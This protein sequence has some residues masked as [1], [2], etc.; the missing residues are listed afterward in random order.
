MIRLQRRE[1]GP[2][3]TAFSLRILDMRVEIVKICTR[4]PT[5]LI[6]PVFRYR[7]P[8]S[9]RLL[10]REAIAIGIRPPATLVASL[11]IFPES[12]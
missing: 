1:N 9:D 8:K 2:Y 11:H 3:F 6:E 12:E 4:S 10:V 5:V 7:T